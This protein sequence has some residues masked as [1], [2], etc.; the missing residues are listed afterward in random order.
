MVNAIITGLF[1]FT[2]QTEQVVLFRWMLMGLLY[3]GLNRGL[4]GWENIKL[5][6]SCCFFC[7]SHVRTIFEPI[8]IFLPI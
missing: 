1:G 6:R 2:A 3:D 7:S 8:K 4:E 5:S